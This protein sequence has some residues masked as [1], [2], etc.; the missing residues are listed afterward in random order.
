MVSCLETDILRVGLSKPSRRMPLWTE[1]RGASPC[2]CSSVAEVR[3]YSIQIN[4]L[5]DLSIIYQHFSLD[6]VSI[7]ITKSKGSIILTYFLNSSFRPVVINHEMWLRSNRPVAWP[8]S[9]AAAPRRGRLKNC[10]CNFTGCAYSG[11][12]YNI[13]IKASVGGVY[14]L[15]PLWGNAPPFS[16]G[17]NFV[18]KTPLMI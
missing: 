5:L 18:R 15:D 8:I 12:L 14:N 3:F 9:Q 6:L 13:L 17:V 7:V 1:C 16:M 4:I 10:I 11:F 2:R